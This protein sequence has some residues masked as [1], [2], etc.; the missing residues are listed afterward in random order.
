MN[1]MKQ[2]AE[3]LGVGL[4]EEFYLK[5]SKYKHKLTK[6]GLFYCLEDD[7]SWLFANWTFYEILAGELEIIK[8]PILDDIEKEY[9]SNV[10]KPFRNK[11]KHIIK[12]VGEDRNYEC[13]VIKYNNI[14]GYTG[15]M[16][17]PSFEK[18]TIY[19][20]MEVNKKYTLEE[21]GL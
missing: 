7:K 8:K 1:Y 20:G 18:G 21:L 3:M 11:I 13:I 10:V 15:T 14:N 2:I 9:L 19:K 17:F 5:G 12:Y 16:C 4:D 6:D